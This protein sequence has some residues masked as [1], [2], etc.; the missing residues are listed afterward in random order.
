MTGER[1]D[2]MLAVV[3]AIEFG[4]ANLDT[5]LAHL[6][7]DAHPNV[8]YFFCRARANEHEAWPAA[9]TATP[10][11]NVHRIDGAAQA[12]IPHLWRDGIVAAT[13]PWVALL[14]AHCIP[15]RD[16]LDAVLA[17]S[18]GET[19]AGI[20]GWFENDAEAK[21][22][23]WA[24]YLLRYVK[25]SLP[26]TETGCDNVAADNAVYRRSEVMRHPDLLA[27]GFWEPEFHRR[28]FARGMR[29]RLVPELRVVHR[30]RY[31]VSQFAHQ[32]RDHGYTFGSDRA[33]R[34]GLGKLLIYLVASPLVPA[35]LF[36]K[37]EAGARRAL[38]HRVTPMGT[39]LWLL[40]F[41]THWASGEARGLACELLR[42]MGIASCKTSDH[43]FQ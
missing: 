11:P 27:R 1:C 20:G 26:R 35:V 15:A 40:Y 2:A 41:I 4:E 25:F 17:L 24:L 22:A 13:A 23:D 6:A 12:R 43:S 21:A 10:P 16:W 29:L 8:E 3:V 18:W 19:D 9:L 7:P 31:A 34:S 36:A 39:R 42:R 37:I 14:T 28:F 30:N 33:R 38:E 32:R 5:V